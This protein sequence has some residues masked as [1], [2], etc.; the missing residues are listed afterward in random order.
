MF[1]RE[2]V[3]KQSLIK[4]THLG[5][6][7]ILLKHPKCLTKYKECPIM[8]KSFSRDFDP[9]NLN[10]CILVCGMLSDLFDFH[11]I[12]I[13]PKNPLVGKLPLNI[14]ESNSPRLIDQTKAQ[15]LV[16]LRPFIGLEL[17]WPSNQVPFFRALCYHYM[18]SMGDNGTPKSRFN[19]IKTLIEL[20]M[21]QSMKSRNILSTTSSKHSDNLVTNCSTCDKPVPFGD[22]HDCH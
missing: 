10:N 6:R 5:P 13:L 3:N 15:N 7:K 12:E 4:I 21:T 18:A 11:L 16:N 1:D 2:K 14:G 9:Q 20:S 8:N 17:D 19:D 22:N